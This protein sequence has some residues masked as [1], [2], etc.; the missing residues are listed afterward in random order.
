MQRTFYHKYHN[1]NKKIILLLV[2]H[3]FSIIKFF[4]YTQY[5]NHS[6]IIKITN[7]SQ[8]KVLKIHKI[9]VWDV[10]HATNRYFGTDLIHQ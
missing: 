10:K 2:L 6:I 5:K 8:Y 3:I 4:S 1:P 9:C 7:T